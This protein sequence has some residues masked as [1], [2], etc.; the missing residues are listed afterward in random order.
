MTE[1]SGS[2]KVIGVLLAG[3]LAK[4]MGGGDKCMRT[5]AGRPLLEHLIDAVGP[6]VDAMILNANGDVDRFAAYGLQVVADVIEGYAGPLAGILT[7][8]DWAAENAPDAGWVVSLATDAPFVPAD[9]VARMMTAIMAEDAEIA[10]A[11]SGGR[12]HPVFGL[13]PVGL[14]G[15]LRAAMINEDTRKIDM[16]T[17]RYKLAVVEFEETNGRDPFFNVN[18]PENLAEAERVLT[19]VG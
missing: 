5:L 1:S 4:R 18:R 15:D 17:A 19:G 13:W 9:M 2:D 6:Q 16:W 12:T 8:L 10:C 11:A 14:C 7:G 3:G